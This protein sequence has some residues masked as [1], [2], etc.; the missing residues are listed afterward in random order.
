MF[1]YSLPNGN[2]I[3]RNA[4]TEYFIWGELQCNSTRYTVPTLIVRFIE[5]VGNQ[6]WCSQPFS[7][8]LCFQIICIDWIQNVL[9]CIIHF[10][11]YSVASPG[12]TLHCN[13]GHRL[14]NLEFGMVHLIFS[15]KCADLCVIYCAILCCSSSLLLWLL[16]AQHKIAGCSFS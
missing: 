3:R 6:S 14:W 16:I 15:K 2:A 5:W 1:D 10:A 8:Y 7:N 9:C 4:C 11:L 12:N 13:V